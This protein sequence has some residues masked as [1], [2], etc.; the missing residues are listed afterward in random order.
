MVWVR[1]YALSVQLF[2]ERH[3]GGS[4]SKITVNNW[5]LPLPHLKTPAQPLRSRFRQRRVLAGLSAR[6]GSSLSRWGWGSLGLCWWGIFST[7]HLH[8]CR[9]WP[10]VRLLL[11]DAS[12]LE[13]STDNKWKSFF[14]PFPYLIMQA[15]VWQRSDKL[16]YLRLPAASCSHQYCCELFPTN[17]F[18]FMPVFIRI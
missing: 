14:F 9:T 18:A 16:C 2:K 17:P 12:L 4:S 5:I 6:I 1:R 13:I 10:L 11:N 7:S 8:P 3:E 15:A